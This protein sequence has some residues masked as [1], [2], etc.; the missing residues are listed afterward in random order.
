MVT[1]PIEEKS[2]NKCLH[3]DVCGLRIRI[4]GIV[5]FL[6]G[7]ANGT[8]IHNWY[9]SFATICKHYDDSKQKE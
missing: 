7:H 9:L 3:H 8:D 5:A 1:E 2:C 4:A 6:Q